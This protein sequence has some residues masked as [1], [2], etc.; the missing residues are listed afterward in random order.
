MKTLVIIGAARRNGHTRKM[1]DLF[2]E[3]LGGEYEIIDAYRVKD[4]EP[5]KDCRFCW[6]K[7]E[8]V[9]KDG[10]QDIYAKLEEADNVVLAS[11][12]YFHSVTG[13]MKA[14]ID[15]FQVYWAGHVRNDMP[16]QPLR[17]GAILMVGGAPSFPN[18]FLGGELVLKNLLNDLSCKFLGEVCLSNS[19]HDSL[20]TRPDIAEQVVALANTMKAACEGEGAGDAA[21]ENA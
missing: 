10:M 12:M 11:P 1:V 5:C 15:R 3:T 8:C 16:E 14:L 18:Q 7:K 2:L 17:N 4:I 6:R 19:D 21:G 20:E 13:K 9:I